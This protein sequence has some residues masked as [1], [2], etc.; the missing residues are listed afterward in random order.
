MLYE[1]ITAAGAVVW[2]IVEG[3]HTGKAPALGFVSGILAGLVAV[4]PA[5]G[6]VQPLGAMALGA[7][8]S[9]ICYYAIMLKD[10]LGYDDTLDAFGLH[11]VGG[12]VGA[13]FLTFFIRDSWWANNPEATLGSQLWAQI[14]AVIVTIVYAGA[15]TLILTWVVDKL[16]GFRS[17][18]DDEMARIT[19]YN[20]CYTKLLRIIYCA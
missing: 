4:T 5:A 7:I 14:F 8:A 2:M 16:L 9:V 17:A 15:V 12:I 3:L 19:S 11:G 1:V 6:V 13:I 18:P 20:V 10:K